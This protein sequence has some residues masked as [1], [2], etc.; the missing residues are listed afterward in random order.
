MGELDILCTLE[1]KNKKPEELMEKVLKKPDLISTIIEG[2]TSTKGKVKFGSTKVLRLIS[3]REPKI[4]YPHMDFFIELLD[5]DNNILK[6]NAQ[7]IIANLTEVDTDNKFDEIFQKYYDFISDDV[8]ITAGHVVDNSGKIAI[9]KRHFQD[10][11]T[12]HLFT[13]EKTPRNQECKNILLGKAI[14]SFGKYFDQMDEKSQ[15]KIV[16][17]VKRQLNNSR[18]ATK[19]KAEAFL[20]RVDSTRKKK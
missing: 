11:I 15:D 2:T 16:S 10:K 1:K 9:T 8:M 19:K 3:E 12:K 13:V 17:F 14:L 18:V 6:W 4:L 7:D 20:K 5:S